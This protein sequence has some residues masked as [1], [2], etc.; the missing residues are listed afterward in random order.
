MVMNALKIREVTLEAGR[1]KVVVP[2]I[3]SDPKEIIEE[4]EEIKKMPCQVV[5]WRA[6]R[7]LGAIDDLQKAMEEKNFYLDIVKILDDINFIADGRPVIFTVRT[8]AE[9]GEA[10]I[11]RESLASI[12]SLA[13]QSKLADIIDIELFDRDGTLDGEYLDDIISEIHKYGCKVMISYHDFSGMPEPSELVELAEIMTGTGADIY[14]IAAM[15][16]SKEDS[17]K[18]LKAT[19]YLNGKNIGPLVTVAMGECGKAARVAAGR[20]GSCMTFA[21]GKELS[22]PGQMDVYAMK[23]LLDSYYGGDDR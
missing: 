11:D 6:D 5:E 4:C 8:E 22:A 3:S 20:Y 14:K 10:C 7:Y 15:A 9:G 2:V 18:L 19:A 1:P 21:S 13:A 17:E 23:K 12:Q 16:F